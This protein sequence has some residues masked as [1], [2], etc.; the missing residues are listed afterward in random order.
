MPSYQFNKQILKLNAFDDY[1]KNNL[2]SLYV[3]FSFVPPFIEPKIEIV[4]SRDLTTEEQTTLTN[5]VN[6]YVDP[7]K[8]LVLHHTDNQ[9]FSSD[10][11]SSQTPVVVQSFIV[12][13]FNTSEYV[14][15]CL[16]TIVKI[17]AVNAADFSDWNGS[18]NISYTLELFDFTNNQSVQTTTHV[19]NDIIN[20]WKQNN[21]TDPTWET[22][23][24]YGLENMSPGSDSI[25]NI[26]L[27]V[28][29]PRLAIQLN[30]MQKLYYTVE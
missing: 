22:V 6:S 29:D 14:M 12:S 10:I 13:P 3:S 2:N 28:S 19:L 26:K 20:G 21:L 15:G 23:Q 17:D 27:S 24:L 18:P 1:L 4:T 16:K 30:S 5:L 8:W 9:F 7:D 11:T 25:W